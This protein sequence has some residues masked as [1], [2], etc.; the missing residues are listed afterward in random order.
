MSKTYVAAPRP[1]DHLG[2]PGAPVAIEIARICDAKE[3]AHRGVPGLIAGKAH[4]KAKVGWWVR[5][6]EGRLSQKCA[7]VAVDDDSE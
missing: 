4:V 2:I 1:E 3:V 6:I 5:K 7:V